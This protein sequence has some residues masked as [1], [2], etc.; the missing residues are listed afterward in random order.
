MRVKRAIILAAGKGERLQPLTLKMPKPLITVNGVRMIESIISALHQNGI[1]EIYIVVGYMKEQFRYLAE[2]DVA[3]IENPWYESANNISSLYAARAHLSDCFIMD[4][5]QIIHDPDVLNP[6]FTRSGYNVTWCEDQTREWLLGVEGGIIRSCSRTGG[7]HGCQLF[8]I[9]RWSA[10]DGKIL[11]DHIAREFESGNR[12]IY[13][14]DVPLFC[15]PESYSLG[16]YEM[17]QGAVQEIDSLEELI[18]ADSS[19]GGRV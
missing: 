11:C 6:E 3:L 2:K 16:V 15:Y 1:R 4:G 10:E 8:S 19:Y 5:D 9:S 17:E 12:D 7:A 13:W 14:D 18:E